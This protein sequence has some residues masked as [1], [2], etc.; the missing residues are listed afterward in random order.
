MNQNILK[1]GEGIEVLFKYPTHLNH[2]HKKQ[3]CGEWPFY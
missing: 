1:E 2:D 3:V